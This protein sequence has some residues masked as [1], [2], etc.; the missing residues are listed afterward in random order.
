[1]IDQF[2]TTHGLL[3]ILHSTLYPR[4]I[5]GISLE[6]RNVLWIFRTFLG[7]CCMGLWDGT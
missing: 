2:L 1:V 5:L 6:R 4:D 3:P 7:P